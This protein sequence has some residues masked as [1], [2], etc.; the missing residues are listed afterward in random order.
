MEATATNDEIKRFSIKKNDVIITK[1]SEDWLD[2]GV[3]ALV[4]YEAKNL[5]C[6]Y[7]TNPHRP[8]P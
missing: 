7:H 2:I 6:G 4:R 1:D 5:I 3:P 8:I